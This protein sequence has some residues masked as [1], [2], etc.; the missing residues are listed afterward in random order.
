MFISY[1]VILYKRIQS[2][3]L[4]FYK[5]EII[6]SLNYVSGI[7]NKLAYRKLDSLQDW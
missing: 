4:N 3:F 7:Y 5:E 2:L 6:I 1:D